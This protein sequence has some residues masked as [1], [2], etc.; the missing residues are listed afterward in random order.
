MLSMASY[1][2]VFITVSSL[3]FA[4]DGKKMLLPSHKVTT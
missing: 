1:I 2:F 3:A 4:E